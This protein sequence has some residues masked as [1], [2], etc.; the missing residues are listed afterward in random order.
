ML[1]DRFFQCKVTIFVF[2][3]SKYLGRDTLEDADVMFLLKLSSTNFH[4]HQWILATT[5]F[6]T[7]VC[8]EDLSFPHSFTGIN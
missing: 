8:G 6:I 7:V 1:S 2:V 3:I 4:I 5:T